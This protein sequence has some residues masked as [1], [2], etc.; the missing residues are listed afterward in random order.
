MRWKIDETKCVQEMSPYQ[1]MFDLDAETY[2]MVCVIGKFRAAA[3]NNGN[4]LRN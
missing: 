3:F 1:G 4:R 2:M